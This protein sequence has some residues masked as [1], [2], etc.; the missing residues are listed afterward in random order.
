MWLAKEEPPD[1]LGQ[2]PRHLSSCHMLV[3]KLR[4]PPLAFS[5]K[6]CESNLCGYSRCDMIMENDSTT[7]SLMKMMSPAPD[8]PKV[9]GARES[10]CLLEYDFQQPF[11][12]DPDLPSS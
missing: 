4:Y 1:V 9:M 5:K 3:V 2:E 10:Y 11:A 12:P 8:C 7:L 6:W